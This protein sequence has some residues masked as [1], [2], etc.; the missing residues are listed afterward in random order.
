MFSLGTI[1]TFL[2]IGLAVTLPGIGSAFGVGYVGK[3]ASGV[4]SEDPDKFTPSLLLQAL[5]A[6]QGIYGLAI[7]LMIMI[8]T[9]MLGGSFNTQLDT[10]IGL[11][12]LL[13]AI[14]IAF[15]G[16]LSAMSQGK[17]AASGVNIIA[18]KP[19]ALG[20]AILFAA[21]VETFAI[22]SLLASL[23]MVLAVQI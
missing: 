7:G 20:K 13:S 3:A 16:L 1:L 23:L 6:T 4:V 21:M 22:L 9:G 14:P 17:V 5:P 15:V 11:A 10:S 2:A 8:R 18:K 19:E 12:L